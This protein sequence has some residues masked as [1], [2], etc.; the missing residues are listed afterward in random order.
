MQTCK[1]NSP[2]AVPL[3]DKSALL[4]PNPATRPVPKLLLLPI[5]K[6]RLLAMSPPPR[7]IGGLWSHWDAAAAS[8]AAAVP[9]G[10]RS[11]PNNKRLPAA[12]APCEENTMHTRQ[13]IAL[14]KRGSRERSTNIFLKKCNTT[15]T[16]TTAF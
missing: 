4:P 6:L 16:T 10:S 1:Y 8:A 2:R 12:A 7:A 5:P 13:G 14:E 3:A 11:S 15:T 9:A